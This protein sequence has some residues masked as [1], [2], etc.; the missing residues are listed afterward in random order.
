MKNFESFLASQINKFIAYRQHLG[1][2]LLPMRYSLLF[3]DRYVKD[4][5][6]KPG[7]LSP[8]FFLELRANLKME[9]KS[10]NG[11][12]GPIRAFFDFMVRTGYYAEN[13]LK[14]IPRVPEYSFAP[15]IFSPEQTDQLIEAVCKR[16]RKEPGY[17]LKDLAEYIAIVLIARCGLRIK[18]SVRLQLYH[19]RC[20]ERTI[21]I[22]KTKFNKDRLIPVPR[23]AAVELDNYLSVRDA[24]GAEDQNPHLLVT[25]RQKGL[26]DPRLRFVFHRAVNDIGIDRPR[27]V[28]GHTVFGSPTPHSLRH[29]FAVNTLKRIQERGD[30]PQHALPVLAVY[31]GHVSY[32]QTATYLK[33]IDAEQRQGLLDFA[34][35]QKENI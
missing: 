17:Y 35:L 9:P 3:F 32:Q 19:Y 12:L 5:K 16:I 8:S 26:N 27:Q 23:S 1:Y 34:T 4:K 22:E 28:I 15:F 13:P 7:V 20:R 30:C 33:F 11:R 29:S 18:E 25:N 21:Y 14:D 6:I 24:F 2:S 10:V 31:L